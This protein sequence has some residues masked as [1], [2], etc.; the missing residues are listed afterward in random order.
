MFQQQYSLTILERNQTSLSLLV[1]D[2]YITRPTPLLRFSFVPPPAIQGLSDKFISYPENSNWLQI[3][4]PYLSPTGPS[5]PSGGKTG[6]TGATGNTGLTGAT[7]AAGTTGATG[8]QGNTGNTGADSTVPG[9]AGA[10][11]QTGADSTVPGPTG[12]TGV[13]GPTG[14][15]GDVANLLPP[16]SAAV[17][18]GLLTNDGLTPSWIIPVAGAGISITQSTN[19]Y[20][21][22][23]ISNAPSYSDPFIGTYYQAGIGYISNAVAT[24][25]GAAPNANSYMMY[26]RSDGLYTLIYTL[27]ASPLPSS[28]VIAVGDWTTAGGH[29]ALTQYTTNNDLGVLDTGIYYPTA[30]SRVSFINTYP[31]SL[32]ISATD[33]PSGKY[34]T[35]FGATGVTD[36]T[37]THGFNNRD[38]LISIWMPD[39]DTVGERILAQAKVK[40]LNANQIQVSTN[41]PPLVNSLTIVIRE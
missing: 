34:V 22:T 4:D 15:T 25:L 28:Y 18:T 8:S 12:A 5:G 6:D 14:A 16:I 19:N 29:G 3:V 38:L 17:N 35:N 9:P 20:S 13:P 30:G 26:L 27:P 32:T 21:Q 36:Y 33:S 7:G 10:T 11:G 31:Q 23:T 24:V 40:T 41:Q 39:P 2:G 1:L 37:I